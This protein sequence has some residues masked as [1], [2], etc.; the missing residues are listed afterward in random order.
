MKTLRLFARTG[1]LCC[2]L[3]VALA[4]IT[5]C[6]ATK[7]T[8]ATTV[9]TTAT[10]T[11][12]TSEATT[13]SALDATIQ[14]IRRIPVVPSH[15]S[16]SVPA[17][18]SSACPSVPAILSHPSTSKR[19]FNTK[20]PS[21]LDTVTYHIT[22]TAKTTTTGATNTTT[23]T[24]NTTRQSKVGEG[25]EKSFTTVIKRIFFVLIALF[26]IFF[27]AFCRHLYHELQS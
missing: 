19:K 20:S 14:V 2:V 24:T 18:Q 5:G 6:R 3:V 27:T 15:G 17:I 7:T 21:I 13:A 25:F 12:A 22:T 8:A 16:P 11:A 4:A 9:A 10:N 23:A 1:I 26:V